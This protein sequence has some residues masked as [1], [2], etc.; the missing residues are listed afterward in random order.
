MERDLRGCGLEWETGCVGEVWRDELWENGRRE[1]AECG[2]KA[3]ILPP[4]SLRV[5]YLLERLFSLVS[6]LVNHAQQKD[7]N[8]GA[9]LTCCES[10][11]SAASSPSLRGSRHTD[12]ERVAKGLMHTSGKR[13]DLDPDLDS[14]MPKPSPCFP[15]LRGEGIQVFCPSGFRCSCSDTEFYWQ[16]WPFCLLEVIFLQIST[17]LPHHLLLYLSL[18]LLHLFLHLM[19]FVSVSRLVY[20]HQASWE[21]RIEGCCCY[22][23]VLRTLCRKLRMQRLSPSDLSKSCVT[24]R[25][26]DSN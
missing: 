16:S 15:G 18:M 22:V 5:F 6:L 8:L 14:S 1:Y 21:T 19:L 2:T 26:G 20:P 7:I 13:W 3:G 11:F 4:I 24:E 10:I 23:R 25:K 17:S 9:G 12:Q